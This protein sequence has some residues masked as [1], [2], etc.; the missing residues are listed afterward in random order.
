MSE[1][2]IGEPHARRRGSGRVLSRRAKRRLAVSFD[3]HELRG[4]LDLYGRKVADGEWRDYAIDFIRDKAVFSVFRRTSE[5]PLYRIE[6]DPEPGAPA[7]RLRGGR[8][9]RRSS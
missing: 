3:R 6:K 4:I 5:M 2:E 1:G 8:R 7:G 9:D